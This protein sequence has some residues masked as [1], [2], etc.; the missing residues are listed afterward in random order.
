MHVE[1]VENRFS[2]Y[3]G[4]DLSHDLDLPDADTFAYEYFVKLANIIRLSR[5]IE[6]LCV[7]SIESTDTSLWK[8]LLPDGDHLQKVAD[9]G[10]PKLQRLALQINTT[11]Q[12]ARESGT[13]SCPTIFREMA[14]S[15]KLS[16]FPI[17]D[18]SI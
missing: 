7:I 17:F 4:N 12:G 18:T 16:R 10:F 8:N 13:A 1:Y 14:A 11:P 6:Q 9:H 5:N 2:D 3:R 15:P